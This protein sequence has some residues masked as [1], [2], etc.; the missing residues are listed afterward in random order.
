LNTECS[1][2]IITI[3]HFNIFPHTPFLGIVTTATLNRCPFYTMT[4]L[5]RFYW[6]HKNWAYEDKTCQ[7]STSNLKLTVSTLINYI[8]WSHQWFLGTL[9]VQVFQDADHKLATSSVQVLSNCEFILQ[10]VG[11]MAVNIMECPVN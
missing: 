3:H 9:Q 8:L 7:L 6:V 11:L 2:A 1:Q 10:W 4:R 5:Y